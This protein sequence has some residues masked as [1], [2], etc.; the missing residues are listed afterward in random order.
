VSGKQVISCPARR[1]CPE[2]HAPPGTSHSRRSDGG[3]ARMSMASIQQQIAR[4]ADWPQ[5]FPPEQWAIYERVIAEARTRGLRFAVGGGLAAMTYAGQWRNTK[6]IDLYVLPQDRQA[7]IQLVTELGLEDLYQK[8]PYDRNWIYRSYKDDVI[9]DIMWAMANQRAQVDERWLKGPLVEA[10]GQRFRL[11]PAEE[12]IWS[13]LYVLQR[14][15]CDWPDAL[16]LLYG[17]GPRLDWR[18][19]VTRAAEDRALLAA[20]LSAFAWICPERARELP[21]WL[22]DELHIAPP[23]DGN[24]EVTRARARLLDSRPWFTPVLEDNPTGV[25]EC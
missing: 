2:T 20:L 10:G 14:D 9:V 15:R 25:E 4:C 3:A 24:G 16:N 22:W 7:M 11:L 13:K 19:L 6:D 12:E 5:R 23:G 8:E 1:I 17:V 18:R 21:A